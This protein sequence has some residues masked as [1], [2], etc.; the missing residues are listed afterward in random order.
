MRKSSFVMFVVIAMLMVGTAGAGDWQKLGKK[1]VV[2]GNTEET[3]SIATKGD[4]VS[5][6]EFKIS[7]EWVRLNQVTLNFADGTTQTI[8]DIENVKPGLTS[9]GITITGGPKTISSIDISFQAASSSGNGRATVA[10]L[11][12]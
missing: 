9:A 2:F 11:G 1:T 7:G 12:Q 4:A 3:A 6:I 8:E 5:Q 10:F